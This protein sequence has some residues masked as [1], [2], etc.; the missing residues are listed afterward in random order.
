MRQRILDMAAEVFQRFGFSKTTMEDIA[1]GIGRQKSTLYYYFQS[2]EDVFAAV[3][4]RE[5]E[6]ELAAVAQLEG[7]DAPPRALLHRHAAQRLAS[8]RRE[9]GMLLKSGFGDERL[10]QEISAALATYSLREREFMGRVFG[11]V[12]LD[13]PLLPME[14]SAL[15]TLAQSALREL[16]RRAPEV[17][18]GYRLEEV[19]RRWV[20][21]LWYGVSGYQSA[22]PIEELGREP[23]AD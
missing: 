3:V 13:E 22:P 4:A 20:N 11:R 9:Y 1:Q 18:E 17:D 23:A 21:F 19:A 12:H 15:I 6:G 10:R 2:K 5:L 8:A 7:V 16:E 14:I